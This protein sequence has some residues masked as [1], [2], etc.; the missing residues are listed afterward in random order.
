M[1]ETMKVIA[2]N[3]SPRKDKGNTAQILNPFLDGIKEKGA[4]VEVY[5]TK[6]LKIDPCRGDMTCMRT[7]GKCFLND[8][9]EW[10]IPKI[11]NSDILVFAS[12]L[13]CDGITDL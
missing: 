4:E 11:A 3:S 8:D 6:E 13:Y 1:K 9:M 7:T 5:Y 12:P 10:L 2:I